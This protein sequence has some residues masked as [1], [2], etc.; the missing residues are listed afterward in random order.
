MQKAFGIIELVFVITLLLLCIT[1]AKPYQ[2]NQTHRASQY[3]L[4]NILYTKNLALTQST[5]YTTPLQSKW[6]KDMFPSIA[7]EILITKPM[8]WQ[9]QFHLS[10]TYTKN[11]FSI[12]FD[13]PRIAQ[14]THYDNR[15]MAGDLIAIQGS[16]LRCIS[17]Y[18]NTN[19]A[20]FCKN[21]AETSTRLQESYGVNLSITHQLSCKENK[22]ARIYFDNQGKPYCGKTPTPLTRPFIIT[23]SKN[24]HQK[25]FCIL[26]YTGAIKK[27]EICYKI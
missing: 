24:Y 6:L 11:S 4:Q 23:L 10:G 25:T 3:L 27:G 16:N 13:T 1:L 18:N 26:P 21:N 15:P 22:T 20:D 9:I 17:G 14:T 5:I 8:L 7:Q 19:I 12:Y 2:N